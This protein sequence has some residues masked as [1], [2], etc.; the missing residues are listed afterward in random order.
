MVLIVVSVETITGKTPDGRHVAEM[1]L[2]YQAG[3][4]PAAMHLKEQCG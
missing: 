1:Q 3:G 4:Y 2:S